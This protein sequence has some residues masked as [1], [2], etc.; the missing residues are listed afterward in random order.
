MSNRN[1][2]IPLGPACRNF[3]LEPLQIPMPSCGHF[4]FEDGF[5]SEVLFATTFFLAGFLAAVT[6]AANFFDFFTFVS[7][8]SASKRSELMIPA[9]LATAIFAVAIFS[10]GDALSNSR[11]ASVNDFSAEDFNLIPRAFSKIL[12]KASTTGFTR[13][14]SITCFVPSKV[15]AFINNLYRLILPV[16]ENDCCI[17]IR[18]DQGQQKDGYFSLSSS[19]R[20]K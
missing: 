14:V 12:I 16:N 2:P 19:V 13:A 18:F 5:F 1:Y 7:I 20:N 15:Y 4:R 8:S 9:A 11:I 6:F 10:F 17:I 3:H